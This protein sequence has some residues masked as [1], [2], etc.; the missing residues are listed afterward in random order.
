MKKPVNT[1]LRT[2]SKNINDEFIKIIKLFPVRDIDL[3]IKFNGVDVWNGMLCDVIDQGSCG[4]CW[5]IATASA[6][7]DRFN[8]QSRGLLNIQLSPAKIILC[9]QEGGNEFS[10]SPFLNKQSIK[11]VGCYGNSLID[12]CRYLY[13]FGT[14]EET[15]IP[16]TEKLGVDNEFPSL[17]DFTDIKNIPLCTDITGPFRDRCSYDENGDPQRLYR[18]LHFYGIAGIPSDR[19]SSFNIQS[20]LYKWG[21]V[22]TAFQVYPDFYT[23]NASDKI[24]RWNGKGTPV[25]GH[26]VCIMGWGVE[27]DQPYWIIKNSWGVNWGMNGYFRIVRGENHCDIEANCMGMVPDFFYPDD[28]KLPNYP[29][30]TEQHRL[31]KERLK[32][33]KYLDGGIHAATGY[34]QRIIDLQPSLRNDILLNYQKD[35]PD[36][37]TFIAA[38]ISLLNKDKNNINIKVIITVIIILFI[39]SIVFLL[40]FRV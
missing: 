32:V 21:P 8:I 15:C 11:R 40:L 16:Y 7:G 38:E 27:K 18:A 23:F 6:L 29:L 25:G 24:Y 36:W 39:I 2:H 1:F 20:N 35:L 14:P 33:S 34:A 19:G 12:A 13:Q 28:Y 37:N 3:P 9:D 26:A 5:A 22:V 10:K 31:Q 17:S 30:T 4:S